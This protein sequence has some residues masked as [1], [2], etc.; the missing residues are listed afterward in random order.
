MGVAISNPKVNLSPSNQMLCRRVFGDIG[1]QHHE[2]IDI[3]EA[4]EWWKSNYSVINSRAMFEAVDANHDGVITYQEWVGFW[5]MVKNKGHTDEEIQEELYNI[6][7]HLSWVFLDGVS[8]L[9][10]SVKE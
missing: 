9:R 4:K 3:N 5:T 2:F 8:R 6:L 7:A 1:S 10:P